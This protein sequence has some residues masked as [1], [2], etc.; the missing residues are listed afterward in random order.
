MIPGMIQGG[1]PR[2][3]QGCRV[4]LT[5]RQTCSIKNCRPSQTNLTVIL[6]VLRH[7]K[8]TVASS[9]FCRGFPSANDLDW[10]IW[11]RVE[12][13]SCRYYA[14]KLRG[15]DP[16]FD[17]EP[18]DKTGKTRFQT[19]PCF[20]K[21]QLIDWGAID[22]G[23]HP[24]AWSPCARSIGFVSAFIRGTSWLSG[25]WVRNGHIIMAGRA[26]NWATEAMAD[27]WL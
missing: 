18:A 10:C 7:Y 17:N 15:P 22:W 9:C 27:Q 21:K 16:K 8:K 1:S 13:E 3:H 4:K 11:C 20:E 5:R 24:P 23:W 6:Y 12:V 26:G 19:T 14:W 2:V 25:S